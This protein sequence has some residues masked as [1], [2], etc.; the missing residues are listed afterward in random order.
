[1]CSENSHPNNKREKGEKEGCRKKGQKNSKFKKHSSFLKNREK[2]CHLGDFFTTQ[3]QEKK[4]H[5]SL[6]ART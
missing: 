2:R 6:R 5:S 3:E 1:L 4:T